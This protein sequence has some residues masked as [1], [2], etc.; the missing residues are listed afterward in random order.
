[1]KHFTFDDDKTKLL[2]IPDVLVIDDKN[3][4][5]VTFSVIASP[6][7]L[8]AYCCP[9]CK[10]SKIQQRGY[11]IR[12]I[13]DCIITKNGIRHITI[14]Y[15]QRQ[16]SCRNVDCGH[17]FPETVY[18]IESKQT[19]TT[20]LQLYT[21]TMA[22]AWDSCNR[23][24]KEI[25]VSFNTIL[26]WK[27]AIRGWLRANEGICKKTENVAISEVEIG[28]RTYTVVANLDDLTL[29]AFWYGDAIS[30]LDSSKTTDDIGINSMKENAIACVRDAQQVV[31]DR[32]SDYFEQVAALNNAGKK[33]IN[34]EG[35]NDTMKKYYTGTVKNQLSLY[36][37]K[38]FIG[39]IDSNSIMDQSDCNF[40]NR[41]L[42]THDDL[43]RA[44][45]IYKTF[46][47][48][49]NGGCG[50]AEELELKQLTDFL[51]TNGVA[52]NASCDDIIAMC[53]GA[54][55]DFPKLDE[56][57]QALKNILALVNQLLKKSNVRNDDTIISNVI[58]CVF[59]SNPCTYAE[60]ERNYYTEKCRGY[61]STSPLDGPPQKDGLTYSY[62]GRGLKGV[63]LNLE[64]KN[65]LSDTVSSGGEWTPARRTYEGTVICD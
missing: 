54:V 28:K 26:R 44:H 63:I 45:E 39:F 50:M 21:Y 9:K 60:M 18:G 59:F 49:I 23:L 30:L 15:H 62:T 47:L 29:I 32:Y 53:F 37:S 35:L 3:N 8:R 4:D 57:N 13:R 48:C 22:T 46:K 38:K 24:A 25:G 14:Q 27:A 64:Y 2:G 58:D 36:Q 19:V 12:K 11:K 42:S 17:S 34:P 33:S 55:Q 6:S 41:V 52:P 40:I 16:F 5:D 10:Q 65:G 43:M 7:C 51:V 20:R 31:I 1:M 61:V 56:Y